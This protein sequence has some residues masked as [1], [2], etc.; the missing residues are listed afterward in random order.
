MSVMSVLSAICVGAWVCAWSNGFSVVS[1]GLAFGCTV[2]L[3]AIKLLFL[4]DPKS[5]ES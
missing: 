1:L 3:I 4:F 2:Q 5:K